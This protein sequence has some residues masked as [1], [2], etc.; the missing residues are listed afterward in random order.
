MLVK[1]S[2]VN[3][4]DKIWN[5]RSI[6]IIRFILLIISMPKIISIIIK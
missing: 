5:K 6:E 3:I 2:I 4:I 1:N